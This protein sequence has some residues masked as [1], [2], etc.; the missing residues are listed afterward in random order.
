MNYSKIRPLM[1]R[2]LIKKL[3]PAKNVSKSGLLLPDSKNIRYGLVVDV[4]QGSFNEDGKLIKP[5]LVKGQ[6]VLLPEYGG[7]SVPKLDAKQEEEFVFY[8]D[9]DILGVVEGL[10]NEKRL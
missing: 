1:S 8:Q 10:E 9:S 2:V 3:V 4:G 7:S 6:Y 5:T